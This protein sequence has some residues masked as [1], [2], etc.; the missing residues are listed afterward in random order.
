MSSNTAQRGVVVNGSEYVLSPN[1][2]G[3]DW[4]RAE[5]VNICLLCFNPELSSITN[6]ALEHPGVRHPGGLQAE[7]PGVVI[8]T[9]EGG[10]PEENGSHFTTW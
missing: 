1:W 4:N 9:V 10:E 3:N 7:A 2:E 8:L 6:L 5:L